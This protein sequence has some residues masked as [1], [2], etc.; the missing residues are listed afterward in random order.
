MTYLILTYTA[1]FFP[2]WA[3][4]KFKAIKPTFGSYK[5]GFSSSSAPDGPLA[6][7]LFQLQS[8]EL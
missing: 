8:I 6:L 3:Q 4:F 5:S 1:S 2:P 7:M